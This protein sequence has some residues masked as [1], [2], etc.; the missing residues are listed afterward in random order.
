MESTLW[1]DTFT[2]DDYKALVAAMFDGTI[3]VSDN[4]AEF[5]TTAVAVEQYANIKG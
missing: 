2:Q 3:V 5:P 1:S 4:I